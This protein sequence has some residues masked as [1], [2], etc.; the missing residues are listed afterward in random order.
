MGFCMRRCAASAFIAAVLVCAQLITAQATRPARIPPGRGPVTTRPALINRSGNLSGLTTR[1]TTSPSDKFILNF[2]DAPLDSVIDYFSTIGGFTVVKEGPVDGRVTLESKQA[3]TRQE[4]VAMLDAALKANGFAAIQLERTLKILP[5]DKAKKSSVPVHFGIDPKDIRNTDELITQVM[6]LKNVDANKLKDD[7]KPLMDGQQADIA[8]NEA[9]N[10]LV[11]TDNSANIRRIA[12]IIFAMDQ[13]EGTTTEVRVW[14]LHYANATSAVKLIE[15]IF[16]PET[17][18]PGRPQPGQ[19]MMMGPNGPQP[20]PAAAGS[21]RRSKAQVVAA[22]DDRTNMIVVTGPSDSLK[23]VDDILKKLDSNPMPPSEMRSFPL[24][25]ADA[26]AISKLVASVFQPKDDNSGFPFRIFFFGGGGGDQSNKVKVNTAFDDRT[27]TVIV[28]APAEAMKEIASMIDRLDASPAAASGIRIFP[29]KYADSYS[30]AKLINSIFNPPPSDSGRVSERVLIFDDGM[31]PKPT[32]AAKVNATSD[33]RTNAV[34]VTA[35]TESLKTVENI[36]K[37]LDSSPGS[38]DTVFIYH[39]RNAQAQNLEVVLNTLFGNIE[40]GQGQGQNNQNNP[41]QQGGPNNN[42]NGNQ[43]FGQN[44]Q[45]GGNNQRNSA[46][47]QANRNNRAPNRNNRSNL[48]PGSIKAYS[49]LTGMVLVVAEP[50]TNSLIV[51]TAVKYKEE[52]K[53]IIDDLDRPAAQVLI[54]VLVAEVTH[55][56][57]ADFGTD[58]SILN[59]RANG[60]GQSFGQ[61]FGTPGSGLVVNFLEDNLN[62][63][64]HALAQQNKLDVLSR[65]YI[66]ASDN[67][68][69]EILVGQ[70]VPIVRNSFV[71]QFGTSNSNYDYQSVGII[72]DVTPH[73]NP[74]GQVILDVSPEISQLTAQTVNVSPGVN[75]PVIADRSAYSTVGIRDGQTIVIGGLMQDQK[76]LT[77]NKIPI[78]GDIPIIGA[79]FSRTQIDKTKT[80]LLIF[81]TPH[82]AQAPD[83]LNPMSQD[84]LRG[85]RLTPNAVA[86]GTFDEHMRNMQ[87][88]SVPSMQQ[89]NPRPPVFEPETTSKPSSDV[90]PTTRPVPEQTVQTPDPG[91]AAAR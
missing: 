39:L 51:T 4:A 59:T 49:E 61:T 23:M 77:V 38:E 50:D 2:K 7:L 25:Y 87:R 36:V 16:K 83:V 8:A 75:V 43:P 17:G 81:L 82:V 67:K 14:P 40:N 19:P 28:T 22:A 90:A 24:K 69:A 32:K 89:A 86:P 52:V 10:T 1:P 68:P 73:I 58:F 27:N 11:I 60:N 48:Q 15:T 91:H 13:Q 72:L 3:V 46:G 79:I 80:E 26:E 41:N 55:D 64:L 70:L 31:Q 84:E 44:N 76:T 47:S 54:K 42:N 37:Q 78:I 56:N 74:D 45:L 30:A 9:S 88:G 12:T 33:D 35:P 71:N 66:L 53:R 85:T 6:P 65:P 20:P 62:A 29:L 57:N 21:S 18:A 5:R 63:Q 34:V